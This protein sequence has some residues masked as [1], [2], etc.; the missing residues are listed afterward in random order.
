MEHIS[1]KL[2]EG[3]KESLLEIRSSNYNLL[4]HICHF[5]DKDIIEASDFMVI[6]DKEAR[7]PPDVE[8][9]EDD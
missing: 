3:E 4:R 9:E 8:E 6:I 5:V 7:T 1:Y 2:R